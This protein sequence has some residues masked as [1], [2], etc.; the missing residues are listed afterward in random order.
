MPALASR[1]GMSRP[2]A[3]LVAERKLF[4]HSLDGIRGVA[5]IL[6]VLFHA[7]DYFGGLKFHESYLAVDVFFVLSGVVI[8]HTYE[9]RLSSEMSVRRFVWIRIVR[10]YPLYMLGTGLMLAAL[11]G[12]HNPFPPGQLA[13]Y[14][15]LAVAILPNPGIGTQAFFP[16]N[17]PAWSLFLELGVN[18]VYAAA[19]RYLTA[20]AI[21]LIMAVSAL[22]LIGCLIEVPPHVL[23]M[24]WR[25]IGWHG[26]GMITGICRVGYSFFAG[27]LLYRLFSARTMW[28]LPVWVAR[29]APWAILAAITA[30]LMTM[31]AASLRPYYDLTAVLALFPLLIYLALWFQPAG[32]GAR[33]CQV[34]GEISYAVYAIH[35]PLSTLVEA[36]VARSGRAS[37]GDYAPW[38]GFAFVLLL[39]PLC[40]W[41]GRL[42]DAPL[43]RYLLARGPAGAPAAPQAR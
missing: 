21:L 33:I 38:A 37:I 39:L 40:W 35:Y 5:A 28:R 22:G 10:I 12:V 23:S 11:L 15:A 14:A 34:L 41:L 29:V 32:L 42:Y 43:R 16:L 13:L 26:F 3:G 7:T 18:V 30:L 19:L 6:V 31:P 8:S 25:N 4:F 24:G 36:L 1:T 17:V 20:R 27:V 9:R 2:Q